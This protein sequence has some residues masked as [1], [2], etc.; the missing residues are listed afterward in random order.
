[1]IPVRFPDDLGA[2]TTDDLG[3]QTYTRIPNQKPIRESAVLKKGEERG[4][5][6][7][8]APRSSVVL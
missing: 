4:V 8:R 6:R 7:E 2:E 5:E 3:A 1:M